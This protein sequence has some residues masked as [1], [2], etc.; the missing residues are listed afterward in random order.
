MGRELAKETWVGLEPGDVVAGKYRVTRIIGRGGVGIVAEATHEADDRRVAIKVLRPSPDSQAEA[1]TRFLFEAK[2]AAQMKSVHIARILEVSTLDDGAPYFVMEF[3]EGHDLAAALKGEGVLSVET[4]VDYVI[5]TCDAL[6]EA[7]SA[8]IVHGD[9]KP[10][11]LFLTLT[12]GESVVVKLLDFGISKQIPSG[13]VELGSTKTHWPAI[14]TPLY[15]APE[16]LR[17]N[18]RVDH[19]ADIWALGIMLHESLTAQMPFA[20]TTLSQMSAAIAGDAPVRCRAQRPDL[21]EEIETIVLRCLEKDA[22]DRFKNVGELANALLPFGPANAEMTEKRIATVLARATNVTVAPP[23]PSG[24]PGSI[25][26]LKTPWMPILPAMPAMPTMPAMTVQPDPALD[27][28]GARVTAIPDPPSS[29]RTTA[30]SS[31]AQPEASPRPAEAVTKPPPPT[32]RVASAAATQPPP[33]ATTP[34]PSAEPTKPPPSPRAS[35]PTVDAFT[36]PLPPETVLDGDRAQH[37]GPARGRVA[38]WVAVAAVIAG[39]GVGVRFMTSAS[40]PA[41][42]ATAQAAA[43]GSADPP[44]TPGAAPLVDKAAE[45]APIRRPATPAAAPSDAPQPA[46]PAASATPSDPSPVASAT[47]KPAASKS[48]HHH[49]AAPATAPGTAEPASTAAFGGSRE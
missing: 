13:D 39:L 28:V 40:K 20:G 49:E 7:H 45:V 29:A 30:P 42:D 1:T 27:E 48:A 4:A 41:D 24:A 35:V 44:P 6:A 11:N 26:V 46:Q 12:E 17:S 37:P 23:P 33:A 2:A 31:A 14:G 32:P 25:P 22:D 19:R 43:R 3:L 47:S 5:Q 10:S 9:L 21:P 18:R 8:G 34:A 38:L 16:Q 36:A 15:I